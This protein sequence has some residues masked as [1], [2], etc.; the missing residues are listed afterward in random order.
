MNPYL[1]IPAVVALLAALGWA[2][3]ADVADAT[4]HETLHCEMVQLYEESN[5]KQ[6]WPDYDP[7]I[8]CS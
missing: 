6:G 3:N 4:D 1:L 8:K 5:G 7:T 2:G